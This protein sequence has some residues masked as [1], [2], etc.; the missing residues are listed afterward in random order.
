MSGDVD[1]GMGRDVKPQA[2]SGRRARSCSYE[3]SFLPSIRVCL[4]VFWLKKAIV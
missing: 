1:E 3:R 2:V 4:V